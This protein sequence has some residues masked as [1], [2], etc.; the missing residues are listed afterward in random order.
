MQF[1]LNHGTDLVLR[2]CVP[3]FDKFIDHCLDNP[4]DKALA[5]FEKITD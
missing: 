1:A 3:D 5:A 2:I 4:G